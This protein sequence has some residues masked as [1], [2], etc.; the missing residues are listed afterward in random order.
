MSELVYKVTGCKPEIITKPAAHPKMADKTDPQGNWFPTFSNE[1]IDEI[2][3][4]TVKKK[5]LKQTVWGVK[6]IRGNNLVIN[7]Q[8][9]TK[10]NS[11]KNV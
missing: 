6:V 8:Y 2:A 11:N 5:T 1:E 3:G 9:L 7:N 10:L 4:N